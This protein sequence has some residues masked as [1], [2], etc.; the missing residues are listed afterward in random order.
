MEEVIRLS[1]SHLTKEDVHSL[2]VY[3]RSLGPQSAPS[4]PVVNS[5]PPALRQTS[6]IP[7]DAQQSLGKT[8]FEGSCA[9]CH[10]WDGTGMQTA[11]ADLRGSGAVNDPRATNLIQVV[12]NGASASTPEGQMKMPAFKGALSDAEIAALATYV[13]NRF[14][15]HDATVSPKDVADARVGE[16]PLDLQPFVM[17]ATGLAAAVIVGVAGIVLR[18]R[19]RRRITTSAA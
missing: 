18:R 16:V 17:A 9:S 13:V 8:V 12:L 10:G 1:L 15:G 7:T 11:Y 5:D 4:D 14:G 3:L 2:G 19:N 6:Y